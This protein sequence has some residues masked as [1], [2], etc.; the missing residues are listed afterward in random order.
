MGLK[1]NSSKETD[2]KVFKALASVVEGVDSQVVGFATDGGSEK[3]QVRYSVG[4]REVDEHIM[5]VFTPTA[6]T[7]K[8]VSREVSSRNGL[9]DVLDGAEIFGGV[10]EI[11]LRVLAGVLS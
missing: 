8:V 6:A 3:S 2:A 9:D 1:T 7:R 11:G 10:L 4:A 5:L